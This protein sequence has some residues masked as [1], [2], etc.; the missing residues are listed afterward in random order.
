MRPTRLV[1][2]LGNPGLF[3]RGTRHNLGFVVV[4]A[5]AKR[6]RAALRQRAYQG[7]F[8]RLSVAGHELA[9]LLPQTFM[10]MSGDSLGLAVAGLGLAPEEV[11]V[12]LDDLDLP[13]GSLRLRAAGSSGGHNGLESILQV[14]GTEQVPRLR[15]GIGRPPDQMVVEWVLGYPSAADRQAL[16]KVVPQAVAVL[17]TLAVKGFDA[18]QQL[19]ATGSVDLEGTVDR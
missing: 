10:N 8:G 6:H 3:Y 4:E 13:P 12:V 1:V 11:L 9:L 2:G 7:R 16:E 14:L 5:W 19:A 17:D 18:A 15:V